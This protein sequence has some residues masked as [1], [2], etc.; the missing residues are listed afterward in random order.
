MLGQEPPSGRGTCLTEADEPPPE[1][2]RVFHAG[3][4][5]GISS[6]APED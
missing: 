1:L 2:D 3:P 5:Q 4:L 6:A